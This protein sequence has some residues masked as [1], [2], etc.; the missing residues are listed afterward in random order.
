LSAASSCPHHSTLSARRFPPPWRIDE[1]NAAC[2]VV[3]DSTGQALGYFHFED[4]AGCHPK[5]V[6][7]ALA[8]DLLAHYAGKPLIDPY[9]IY[10]HLMDYWAE[11]MQD[12][13]YMIAADTAQ[14][15]ALARQTLA[16]GLRKLYESNQ[17]GGF[18]CYES[19]QD[20]F[21]CMKRA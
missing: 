4:E 17:G 7:A 11:T 18:T 19:N 12:D 13:C 9:D 16:D 2:F 15:L 5:D 1:A 10:Q 8:E 20:G 14:E 21:T 6:I 3:R